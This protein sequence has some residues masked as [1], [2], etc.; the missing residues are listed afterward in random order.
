MPRHFPVLRLLVPIAALASGVSLVVGIVA[1]VTLLVMGIAGGRPLGGLV[2]GL[3]AAA[4]GVGAAFSLAALGEAAEALLEIHAT[5]MVPP[6][7]NSPPSPPA[8][9]HAEDSPIT[10]GPRPDDAV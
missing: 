6:P 9:G 10:P 7:G 5:I 4:A 8:A 3:A 1:A 2:N